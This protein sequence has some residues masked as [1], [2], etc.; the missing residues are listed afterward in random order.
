MIQDKASE[1]L[2]DAMT[3]ESHDIYF[4]PHQEG[5]DVYFREGDRRLFFE[6]LDK[7]LGQA[8]ISHFKFLA[9]MNTGEKRRTQLGACWY[10]LDIGVKRLR[11]ST[12]G[13]FEGRESL[14]IR[15]LR[16]ESRK[17]EFWFR[18]EELLASLHC[19]RGLYLFAGPVGSG[20]TSL[21]VELAKK[22]FMNKQVITIEDPVEIVES[23]FVQLQVNEVIGNDYDELIKCS[24]RHRPDLLIVGEIRDKKT[25]RAVLRASLT[26]YTVF[27]TVHARSISGVWNRLL[28]LGLS[29]WELKN[30][31]RRV[32]YQRLIAGKGVVDIAESEFEKWNARRWNEKMARLFEDGYL[33]AIEV[34]AEK[35]EFDKTNKIDSV[36]GKSDC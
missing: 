10:S 2:T 30:S 35:V 7:E 32:I 5:Y 25:A 8:I 24:L 36:D 29:E 27:S 14:V 15:I 28:E 31:L 9:G 33:T 3:K 26:G 34:E 6:H 23:D 22:N 20:K 4:I 21:M 1:I 11:M 19:K 12:V 17:L 16:E 18:D 13:D